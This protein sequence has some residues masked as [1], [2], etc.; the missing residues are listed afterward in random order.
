MEQNGGGVMTDLN[1]ISGLAALTICESLLLAL[2]DHNLLTEAEIAGVLRTAAEARSDASD[3][4]LAAL[5]QIMKPICGTWPM[6][7]P[8]VRRPRVKSQT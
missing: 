5:P 3:Q 8:V 1:D 6:K 2:N 7:T 4:D